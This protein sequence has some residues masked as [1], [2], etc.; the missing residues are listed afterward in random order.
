MNYELNK[1]EDV[2][3]GLLY[4]LVAPAFAAYGYVAV[5]A[6]DFNLVALLDK[7]AVGVDACID[8]GFVT[9]GASRFDFVDSVGNLEK[10]ARTFE[11]VRLEVGTQPVAYHIGTEIIDHARELVD[12]LRG[13]ELSF[14]DEKPVDHRHCFLKH[15]VGK[16][17][18]VGVVVYP[19]AFTLDA[20]AR[21][22]YVVSVAGIDYGF[23]AKVAHVAFLEIIC[24]GKEQSR[25]G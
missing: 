9:A 5:V 3:G 4:A 7:V 23:H 18:E 2:A 10:T 1:G 8:D 13:K 22:D 17:V 12:L 21:L 25:L 15:V 20:D 16:L 14:V 6:S 24:C 19:R 11:K